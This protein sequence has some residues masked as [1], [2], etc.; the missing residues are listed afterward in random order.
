MRRS[1]SIVAAFLSGAA[2]L[3]QEVLLLGSSGVC[4]GYGSSA[5][6]GLAAFLVAWALGAGWAG[7]RATPRRSTWWK[8]GIAQAAF[9]PL[10]LFAILALGARGASYAIA[11][12]V[13]LLAIALCALLQGAVLPWIVAQDAG[14]ERSETRGATWIYAA[15]L[16]GSALGAHVLGGWLVGTSGRHVAMAACALLALVA[17]ALASSVA[18]ERAPHPAHVPDGVSAQG[19]DV[20]RTFD[21]RDALSMRKAAWI[22]GVTSAWL[23]ASEWIGLRSAAL[24]F[25]G[26]EPALR[27]ALSASLASLA[28]G[29]FVLPRLLKRDVGGVASALALAALLASWPCFAPRWVP[30]APSSELDT[31]LAAL[32]LVGPPL[33]PLGALV[34]LVHRCLRDRSSGAL[35]RLLL[36][37]SWGIA[38]GLPLAHFVVVPRFG[39]AGLVFACGLLAIACALP[40]LRRPAL[41]SVVPGVALACAALALIAAPRSTAPALRSPPYAEPSLNVLLLR[42]DRDFAVAVVDDGLRG[43]RTLLTDGFRAAGTGDDYRY[44]RVLGHLPV[45]LH[46][47]PKHVAVLALGTGTTL[48]AV[49]LHPEV[50]RIDV[51]EISRAVVDAAP[52]FA[53]VNHRALEQL[54]RVH[55]LLGDGR[56]TLAD[57]PATYD[58]ITMEPLLPDAPFGVYL[59]T[60]EFYANA[61]RAL[62]PGGI[63]CQWVPPHALEP[64]TCDAVL[65]AFAR[66]FPWSAVFLAGTQVVLVGANEAPKLED[67]RFRATG[68]LANALREIGLD[69]PERL[70]ARYVAPPPRGENARAL[71]DADPWIVHRP[72]RRGVVLLGDLPDNLARLRAARAPLPESWSGALSSSAAS[73]RDGIGAL[74]RAREAHAR[75]EAQL[76]GLASSA[77]T[78]DFAR[79]LATARKLAAGD[80]ELASFEREVELLVALRRGVG[81]L[82][83]GDDTAAILALERAHELAPARADTLLYLALARE[84]GG[85]PDAAETL[86]RAL[87]LCPRIA[88]TDAGKRVLALGPSMDTR[89]R[90]ELTAGDARALF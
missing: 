29:A 39:L 51:L 88:L 70:A 41:T 20:A 64:A 3:G 15:N 47:A 67:A 90:L 37:E 10:A 76:R 34:P 81:A 71:T 14:D 89:R 7:A 26:M 77:P 1:L 11:A 84:R 87:A 59:Y 25:G 48:G 60:R 6:L 61:A 65:D 75:S 27:A 40:L 53:D 49:S 57:H 16:A 4:L 38:V 46:P 18:R 45:L 44:M 30:S 86:A 78:P 9:A 28:L 31:F 43:E 54:E 33:V 35:G 17:A 82:Q 19:V 5:A 63:L 50:E 66:A 80:P 13:A 56:R 12:I 22:V 42:E 68:E 55:V 23:V 8:L 73:L 79:E 24:W 62:R 74:Q 52:F 72:R 83:S 85:E 69:T 36:H 32:V 2:G 58:V 21:E